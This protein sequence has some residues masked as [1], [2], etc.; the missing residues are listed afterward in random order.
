MYKDKKILA[1]IPA[2]GGSKGLPRKN[3]KLFLDRPLIAWTIEATK[4]SKYIDKTIVSTDDQNI[5]KVSRRYGAEIPF[6]RPKRLSRDSSSSE[7]V[8][9]H[10]I[11]YFRNKGID[12]DILIL[13]QPTSPLRK[14]VDI[15]NAIKTLFRKKAKA[16]V[17]VNEAVHTP[18]WTNTLPLDGCMKSFLS[19]KVINKNRQSLP[20]YFQ[21]NGAIFI[22]FIDNFI[23]KRSFYVN[24]TFAYIMPKERSV[25]IDDIIDFKLAEI[26]LRDSL[27]R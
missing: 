24:R 11:E 9:I 17:S 15:D 14:H 13:L 3:I 20:K 8:A 16:V 4:A 7:D 18:L 2:R 5:A 12:F 1:V 26:L 22:S 27:K 21:L 25:D 6:L 19:S 10:S 23:R